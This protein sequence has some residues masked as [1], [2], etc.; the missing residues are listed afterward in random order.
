M[1]DKKRATNMLGKPRNK[2]IN[3]AS[4][5]SPKPIH[6]PFETKYIIAK[7]NDAPIADKTKGVICSIGIT[8][9]CQ[10]AVNNTAKNIALSGIK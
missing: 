6:A 4:F 8:V 7:N 3:K 10:R 5:T 9:M 1:K 2:P